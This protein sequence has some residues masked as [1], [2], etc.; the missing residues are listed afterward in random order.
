MIERTNAEIRQHRASIDAIVAQWHAGEITMRQKRQAIRE[1][2]TFFYGDRTPVLAK[3]RIVAAV[4]EP[5]RELV[6]ASTAP[7]W[8]DEP[9]EEFWWQRI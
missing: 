6:P 7:L 5:E 9:E 3:R 1:A 2:N 4:E 8:D